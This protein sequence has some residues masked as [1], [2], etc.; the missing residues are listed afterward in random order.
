M[1]DRRSRFVKIGAV[2]AAVLLTAGAAGTTV[3]AK[4]RRTADSAAAAEENKTGNILITVAEEDKTAM[5]KIEDEWKDIWQPAEES[6]LVKEETVYIMADADG[7]NRRIIV[8]DWIKNGEGAASITDVTGL[9]DITEVKNGESYTKQNGEYVWQ[10]DGNDIY[11]Q[12]TTDKELPLTLKVTYTLDG[13]E[14]KPEEMS[15]RS[16]HIVIRYAFTVNEYEKVEIAGES[17]R[18]CVPFTTVTGMILDNDTFRNVE[19]SAGKVINDGDKTM[20]AGIAFPGMAENLDIDEE[21]L[22]GYVEVEADVTDF[23]TQTAY[24]IAMNNLMKSLNL[25]D[26]DSMDDLTEALD[27]LT[28]A[29]EQLLDGSG[30]LYDGLVTLYDKSGELKTGVGE[31]YDGAGKLKDGAKKLAEGAEALRD[32]SSSL[33]SGAEQLQAGL[34][35]LVSNNDTLNGGAKQVFETLLATASAQLNANE[36]LQQLGISV[37]LTIDNYDEVLNGILENMDGAVLSAV[38]AEVDKNEA[39]ITA[40]VAAVVEQ[41]VTA[42]VTPIVTAAVREQVTA[43]VLQQLQ[44]QGYSLTKEQ[45][46]AVKAGTVSGNDAQTAQLAA[47]VSAA[48]NAIDQ[49]MASARIQETIAQKIQE[50]VGAQMSSEQIQET[51]AA[52]VNAQKEKLVSDNL[53]A[54]SDSLSAGAAQIAGLKQS[55]DSYHTFYQGLLTYTAGVTSAKNGCDQLVDGADQLRAGA[56]QLLGG[57]NEL[58]TGT[59]DLYDGVGTLNEGSDALIDG[60]RQLRDGAKEMKEGLVKFD[61]EGISK[62]TDAFDQE[63]MD[64][65]LDRIRATADVSKEYR[66]FAGIADNMDGNVKFI[67]KIDGIK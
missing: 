66:S 24:C 48:D 28:D 8:S 22:P 38:R 30:E 6:G 3:Y 41:Q 1:L 64:I 45:Y 61:E 10:A 60:V 31:L 26:A 51:I 34:N 53:A 21:D 14:M 15:G 58:Y 67:F 23:S 44:A 4:S 57:A 33:V 42:N 59:E 13:K 63:D 36:Q 65:L 37:S 55:L 27:E 17:E 12:G 32:G 25:D 43:A 20:V 2:C 5:E 29:V 46:D 19:V 9:A 16:G 39:A 7:S 54:M 49:Q 47:M 11:Y 40:G 35:Q 50:T 18:I 62:I 56:V 52:N